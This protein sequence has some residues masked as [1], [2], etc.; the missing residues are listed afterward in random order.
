MIPHF[1]ETTMPKKHNPEKEKAP[2]QQPG[3]Q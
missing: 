2:E 1:K 3:K